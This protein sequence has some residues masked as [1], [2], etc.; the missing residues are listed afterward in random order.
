VTEGQEGSIALEYLRRQYLNV[1]EWY[2][3]A[4]S[5]A[6]ILLGVNGALVSLIGITFFAVPNQLVE[7]FSVMSLWTVIL[8]SAAGFCITG[9][10]ICGVRAI[11]ANLSNARISRIHSDINLNPDDSSTYGPEGMWWFGFIGQIVASARA[12]PAV[13][14]KRKLAIKKFLLEN[15]DAQFE[16]EAL[17]SQ[18]TVLAENT[19]MK[20]RW[21]NRGW[22]F[23]TFGL[24]CLMIFIAMYVIDIA[25]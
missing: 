13:Y 2:K 10:I 1:M 25:S 24:G 16:S 6:Q 18:I 7:R 11:Y 9:S 4:D 20:F 8:L 14:A 12:R 17:A 23:Y 3:S 22:L 19:L 5:K 21:V 15:A